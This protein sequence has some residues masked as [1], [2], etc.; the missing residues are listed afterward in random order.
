MAS[1]GLKYAYRKMCDRKKK[2]KSK[3]AAQQQIRLDI[4][5]KLYEQGDKHAYSC[6]L[7]GY[8]HVGGW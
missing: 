2:H 8:W 7:C 1:G 4:A 5:R 3:W 6:P